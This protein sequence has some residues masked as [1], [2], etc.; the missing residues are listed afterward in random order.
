MAGIKSLTAP[1]CAGSM[2]PQGGSIMKR[3]GARPPRRPKLT[4]IRYYNNRNLVKESGKH[5]KELTASQDARRR[6]Q[7]LQRKSAS[8]DA[9]RAPKPEG[10]DK[11]SFA[12]ILE[13]ELFPAALKALSALAD[14]LG[15]RIMASKNAKRLM[16]IFQRALK[17][18]PEPL[19]PDSFERLVNNIC[20]VGVEAPERR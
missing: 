14:T 8:S 7:D 3:Q 4:G 16:P 15:A 13:K 19:R 9:H 11:A 6:Q 10:S 12:R 1:G 2:P 5:S 20:S 17:R 18:L